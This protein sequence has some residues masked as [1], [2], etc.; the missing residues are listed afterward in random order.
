MN[1][2]LLTSA[3]R[4]CELFFFKLA[5]IQ[6]TTLQYYKISLF[7]FLITVSVSIDTVLL[8]ARVAKLS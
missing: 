8:I 3:V 1:A 6:N 2:A 4:H 7:I 5:K